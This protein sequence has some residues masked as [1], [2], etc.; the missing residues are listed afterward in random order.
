[1]KVALMQYLA[2]GVAGAFGAMTRYFVASLCSRWFGNEFPWGTL[3]INTTG[4]LFLG[5]FFTIVQDHI[6]VS[7]MFRL[8]IAVGFVGAYT[9]FSTFAFESNSLIAHGSAIKAVLN[10]GG[11]LLLGLIAVRLGIVLASR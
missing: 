6:P 2:I 1:M 3:V 4:S 10:M 11:S 9:T 7:D 8:A 5:W